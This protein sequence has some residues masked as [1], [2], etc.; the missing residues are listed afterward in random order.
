[1][2]FYCPRE[3]LIVELDGEVHNDPM[4][5]E[6]DTKRSDWLISMGHKIIRFENK[7]V[8]TDLENVLF[9]IAEQFNSE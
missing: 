8:F 3:K 7:L 4:Q 6:Y 5:S 9:A 1:M 2:D